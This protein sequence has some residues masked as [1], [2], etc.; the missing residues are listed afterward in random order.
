M[1]CQAPRPEQ[2][3]TVSLHHPTCAPLQLGPLHRDHL[4]STRKLGT[5][6]FSYVG[7]LT[8]L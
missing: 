2:C 1:R 5:L 3:E 8:R 7:Q 6:V 4:V